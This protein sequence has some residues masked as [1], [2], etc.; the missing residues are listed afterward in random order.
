MA[1]IINLLKRV[2]NLYNND[3]I[4]II[5]IEEN[6]NMNST[7]FYFN[8]ISNAN[9]N[10]KFTFTPTNSLIN[11]LTVKIIA[12]EKSTGFELE[13]NINTS[14]VVSKYILDKN[15]GYINIYHSKIYLTYYINL[16]VEKNSS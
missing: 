12:I 9:N 3:S 1:I 4:A 15:S 8:E 5:K 16:S 11:N 7:L 14:L 13:S 6:F 2:V 10:F